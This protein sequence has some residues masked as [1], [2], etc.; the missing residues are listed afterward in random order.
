MRC[1]SWL[2]VAA[3]CADGSDRLS[4]LPLVLAASI[5]LVCPARAVWAQSVAPAGPSVTIV[6]PPRLVQGQSA[7]LAVLDS[8]GRLAAGVKVEFGGQQVVTDKTGR[9]Y[10]AAPATDRVL[11]ARAAGVTSVALLE[12]PEAASYEANLS[13]PSEIS[14]NDHFVIFG[15]GFRG[16]ADANQVKLDAEKALVLAA[17]PACL[18]VLPGPNHPPGEAELTVEVAGG[19]SPA[20]R[21]V[22]LV[23][24]EFT[25][26]QP[27]LAPGKRAELTLHVRGSESLLKLRVENLS[28][29]IVQFAR[30][31]LQ[32]L[33]TSGGPQNSAR[34]EVRGIRSGDF[35][36]RAHLIPMPDAAMAQEYLKAA[37]P[38]APKNPQKLVRKL[39]DRLAH[40]PRDSEKVRRELAKILASSPAGDLQVLL[41]AAR[42]ALE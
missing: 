37:L 36:F 22:R 31:N 24:L 40:R 41:E 12:P 23:A 30:G 32:E 27:T 2:R 7:T 25:P 3:A 1:P 17:S 33:R 8:N 4:L 21:G 42:G 6:L 26:P 13:T 28:P 16:D 18:V 29:G 19:K 39:A 35:S 9:A 5:V 11:F 34:I 10:F 38:L 15:G 14:V 20:A